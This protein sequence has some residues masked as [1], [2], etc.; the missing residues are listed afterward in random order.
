MNVGASKD[1]VQELYVKE[2]IKPK[3]LP[4]D[5]YYDKN[6]RM[7]MTEEYHKKRGKCCGN[8]CLHCPF[9]PSYEKGNTKLQ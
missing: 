7:V 4:T 6:G 1:W 8:K 9:E 2:F 3:L 5:F